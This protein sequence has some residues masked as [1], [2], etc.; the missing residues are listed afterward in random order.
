MPS[1][2]V[3]LDAIASSAQEEHDRI[4]REMVEENKRK[5]QEWERSLYGLMN[6][7]GKHAL[8]QSQTFE[9]ARGA[10]DCGNDAGSVSY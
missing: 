2:S 1:P 9:S 8:Q 6:D 3:M 7:N 5:S 4:W 10:Q